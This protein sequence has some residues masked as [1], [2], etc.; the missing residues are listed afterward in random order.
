MKLF[1]FRQK[2][3][4]GWPGPVEVEEKRRAHETLAKSSVEADLG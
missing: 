3:E 1:H 4:A 2:T